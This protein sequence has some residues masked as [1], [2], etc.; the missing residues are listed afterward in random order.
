MT[1]LA[2]ALPL[3]FARPVSAQEPRPVALSAASFDGP[4]G[5]EL[6]FA[7]RFRAGDDPAWAE[8]GLD[9]VDWVPVRPT[10]AGERPPGGWSGV[11]WFRRHLR[12][13]PDVRGREVSFRIASPGEATVFLN[14]VRLSREGTSAAALETA[15]PRREA[16]LAALPVGDTAVL[17]V[18]YVLPASAALR[19]P[20]E[21][22]LPPD[23]GPPRRAAGLD[24][25]LEDR[26]RRRGRLGPALRHAPPSGS[27]SRSTGARGRTSS[28]PARWRS[29]PSS[30]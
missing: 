30:S 8:P 9:D 14:G 21:G 13:A 29:P 23:A 6:R 18:R 25:A 17:A 3:L 15:F 11:G 27:L 16:W 1:G 5:I 26:P 10:M 28:T 2:L 24:L 20:P 4:E 7:W 22:R 12:L 19:S